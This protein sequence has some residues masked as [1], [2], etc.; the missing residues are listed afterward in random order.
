MRMGSVV[1]V[2]TKRAGASEAARVNGSI[3]GGSFGTWRGDAGIAG[4]AQGRMDYNASISSRSTDGAFADILPEADRFEQT[5]LNVGGGVT[6][7][8]R[9]SLRAGLRY[10]DS[11]SRNVG[12]INYGSRDTGGVYDSEDLS[13]HL[14]GAHAVGARY[15]G[16]ASFNYF[17]Y[18]SV[19]EDRVGDPAYGTFAVLEGT[20]GAIFPNGP[21]LVRLV[22]QAEFSGSLSRRRAAGARAIPGPGA[23]LRLRVRQPIGISQAGPQVPGR[24]GL[25]RRAAPERRL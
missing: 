17:R 7:G 9:A 16:N 25:G 22:D 10:S 23:F 2:F 18:D 11:N 4:G 5:A 15:T 24:P 12:P 1:Q 8:T 6:L 21:R 3:E 14:S 13:W 19:S 20:R